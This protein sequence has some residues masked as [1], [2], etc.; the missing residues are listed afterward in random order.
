MKSPIKVIQK[1]VPIEK[2]IKQYFL[3]EFSKLLSDIEDEKFWEQFENSLEFNFRKMSENSLWQLLSGISE[4]YKLK[5]IYN[6]GDIAYELVIKMNYINNKIR[7]FFNKKPWSLSLSACTEA[8]C[9]AMPV[10]VD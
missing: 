9:A 8:R 4:G 1:N 5:W 7:N 2:I 3:H 10:S 6:L